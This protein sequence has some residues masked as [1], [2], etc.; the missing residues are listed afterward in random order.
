MSLT[1]AAARHQDTTDLDFG[2]I[3]HLQEKPTGF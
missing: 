3:N 2:K 1:S